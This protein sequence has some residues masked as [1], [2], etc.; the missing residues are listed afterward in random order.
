MFLKDTK[1]IINKITPM[2]NLHVRA[3]D[4][5][6]VRFMKITE[7]AVA[8]FHSLYLLKTPHGVSISVDIKRVLS[9]I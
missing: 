5:E 9:V 6:T 8:A 7:G 3:T 2:V 4:T 1:N